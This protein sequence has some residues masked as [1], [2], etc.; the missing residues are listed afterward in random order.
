MRQEN[1]QAVPSP[2][3]G[4]TTFGGAAG[5]KPSHLHSPLWLHQDRG[6]SGLVPRM[7]VRAKEGTPCIPPGQRSAAISLR[8][9]PEGWAVLGMPLSPP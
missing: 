5:E 9:H 7:Q 6:A 3:G 1:S 4:H 8:Q 2:Q